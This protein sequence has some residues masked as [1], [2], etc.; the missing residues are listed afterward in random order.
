MAHGLTGEL[1]SGPWCLDIGVLVPGCRGPGAPTPVTVVTVVT[2]VTGGVCGEQAIG[3]CG[4][5]LEC[6]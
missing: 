6:I 3:T 5:V 4:R 2:V 1:V